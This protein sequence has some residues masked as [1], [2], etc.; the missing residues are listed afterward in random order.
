M[1]YRH[2]QSG[3]LHWLFTG[4]AF[5]ALIAALVLEPIEA[6]LGLGAVSTVFAVIT[7][8]FSKLE[9]AAQGGVLGFPRKRVDYAE[10]LVFER[11]RSHLIDSWGIHWVPG[12]GTTWNIWGRDCVEIRTSRGLLRVGTDDPDGLVAHLAERVRQHIRQRDRAGGA[13]A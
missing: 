5:F 9:I 8:S 10:I 13:G 2:V 7:V 11:A 3:R 6:R 12:R 1:T 4:F